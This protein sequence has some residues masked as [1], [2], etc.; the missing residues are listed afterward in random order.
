MPSLQDVAD[1]INAKLDEINVNTAA[2]ANACGAIRT[3]L[4]TLN[5]RVSTLDGHLQAGFANLA[6]GLFAIWEVQKAAL[7]QAQHH[8][9]QHDAI[10]CLLENTNDLLCGITRKMTTQIRLSQTVARIAER[11]EGIAERVEPAAAG[12]FDRLR[13]V[14]ND[15]ARCCPPDP[16]EPEACPEACPVPGLEPYEPDGQDWTPAS[17]PDSNGGP[18]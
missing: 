8:S 2:T 16:E 17:P 1:Q 14:R 15:L 13:D 3:E 12:D 6:G 4:V 9:E 10:I 11:V 7:V 5:G 18:R